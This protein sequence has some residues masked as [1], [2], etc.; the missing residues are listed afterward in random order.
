MTLWMNLVSHR[1]S[2][3][4][5]RNTVSYSDANA[6]DEIQMLID[7]NFLARDMVD[8]EQLIHVQNDLL[9]KLRGECK[10]L[11]EKL[12]DTSKQYR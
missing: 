11:T 5:K 8:L 1:L 12:D 4:W 7:W 2:K 9:D 6:F 3:I 10:M